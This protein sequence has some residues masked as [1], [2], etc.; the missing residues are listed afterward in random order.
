MESMIYTLLQA[1]KLKDEKRTGWELR[2]VREPE[3]VADHSWGTALLCLLFAG[4]ADVGLERTLS[5]AAVH[6]L[7]EAETGDVATRVFAEEQ[8][9]SAEEKQRRELAAMKGLAAGLLSNGAVGAVP[10]LKGGIFELWKEY[11]DSSTSEAVFVRDMNLIDMCLQAL[12]YE[13][14]ERYTE[15]PANPNFRN[16]QGLDEFFATAHPRVQTQTGKRL[17]EEIHRLYQEKKQRFH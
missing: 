14:D 1:Y 6:D 3:S 17:F 2:G 11:E 4:E 8:T 10:A 9:I 7:A 16:F 13:T 15:D 5:I 12:K